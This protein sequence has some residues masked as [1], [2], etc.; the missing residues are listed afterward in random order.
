MNKKYVSF[1]IAKISNN[2]V[3]SQVNHDMR[4]GYQPS[5]IDYKKMRDNYLI[6]KNEKY[7]KQ[8][9]YDLKKEQNKRSKRKIQKNT[10]RFFSGIFSFSSDMSQDFKSNK[11]LY[12]SCAEN[13]C[14]ELEAQYG[15]QICYAVNHLD[16]KTPH[17][18]LL[19]DNIDNNGKSIRRRITPEILKQCQTLMAECFKPMGY[20]RG[21]ENSKRKH[22]NVKE[23]HELNE[24]KEKLRLDSLD[25]K[26]EL[27]I[28]HKI[29][30]NK[31]LT[32]H[33]KEILK[34]LAPSLFQFIEKNDKEHKKELS[35]KIDK[36]LRNKNPM[37]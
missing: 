35:N 2:R 32:E 14:K 34:A 10:E 8:K 28:F 27:E 31:E 21:E 16:E 37:G 12:N 4:I 15:F 36:V 13:F 6:Y 33:E 18:H 19:F 25:Y 7:D 5:Y 9:I 20:V 26:K 3:I 29:L 11:E 22:L 17:I 30:E 23:L 1:R 24:L